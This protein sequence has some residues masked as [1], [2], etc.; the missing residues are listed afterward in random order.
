MNHYIVAR[1]EEKVFLQPPHASTLPTRVFPQPSASDHKPGRL[2]FTWRQ[3]SSEAGE[4][5]VKPHQSPLPEA[6]YRFLYHY[7]LYIAS[8]A[9]PHPAGRDSGPT[10]AQSTPVI[11]FKPLPL[12]HLRVLLPCLYQNLRVTQAGGP[13]IFQILVV[14][15]LS[16]SKTRSFH[17]DYGF[18]KA[19]SHCTATGT[20]MLHSSAHFGSRHTARLLQLK[21]PLGPTSFQ[22]NR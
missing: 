4:V 5:S 15:V 9:L 12:K 10:A 14:G 11:T 8:A 13:S 16:L 3:H 6:F 19:L 22:G 1:R 2:R 18:K 7:S 17:S 20:V 21:R